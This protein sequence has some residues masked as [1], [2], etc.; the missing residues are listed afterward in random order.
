MQQVVVLFTGITLWLPFMLGHFLKGEG[1]N[2]KK[3]NVMLLQLIRVT[4]VPKGVWVYAASFWRKIW[5]K[6]R[7]YFPLVALYYC[8][9]F[10]ICINNSQLWF[11]FTENRTVKPNSVWSRLVWLFMWL[12]ITAKASKLQNDRIKSF[13]N[14]PERWHCIDVLRLVNLKL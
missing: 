1:I 9:I 14:T 8:K 2:Q 3:Q 6:R 11:D 10:K 12:R 5:T 4:K 13:S 7:W